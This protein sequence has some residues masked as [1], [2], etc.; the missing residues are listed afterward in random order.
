MAFD[1][2]IDSALLDAGMTATANAIRA[3]T[4]GSSPIAWDSA[5]GFKVAVEEIETGVELPELNEPAEP[6]EVFSGQ[7]YIDG[8]GQKKT[9]NFTIA[10]ELTEQDALIN[11]IVDALKNKA[12]GSLV[13]LPE[14]TNPATATDMVADKT[15]Y[16]DDGNPVTGTLYEYTENTT[17][18]LGGDNV[19][20]AEKDLYHEG[21]RMLH[22]QLIG[23]TSGTGVIRKKSW[24]KVATPL[25]NLGDAMPEQV[26]KGVTFTSKAGLLAKGTREPS[27]G[28][29][30]MHVDGETLFITGAVTIENETLIL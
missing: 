12:A 5:N 4:G 16:D 11:Q 3:K 15:L 7:E 24:V 14:L 27:S 19:Q 20:V 22:L 26:D 28:G 8:D 13:S 9:G 23:Q 25:T 17:E 30:E 18:V 21:T 29:V 6:E 10:E 1:K 2:V